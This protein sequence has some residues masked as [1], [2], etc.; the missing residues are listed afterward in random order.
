MSDSSNSSPQYLENLL[1]GFGSLAV[2]ATFLAGTQAQ[3][4]SISIGITP[5]TASIRATNVLW[6]SGLILDLMAAFLS[7]LTSRWLQRLSREEKMLLERVFDEQ[8]RNTAR[9]RDY[10]DVEGG[11]EKTSNN[12]NAGDNDIDHNLHAM[13]PLR[14]NDKLVEICFSTSLLVSMPLL[15]FGSLCMVVGLI[16][17]TWSQHPTVVASIVTGIFVVNL[18]F[19]AGVIL[20]SR[21]SSRRRAI[22]HRLSAMQGTW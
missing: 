2:G 20:I 11:V 19:L 7:Y 1:R 12:H 15:A 5:E 8:Q 21:K 9:R 3:V 22:I 16:V 6:L 17:Y 18:P 10:L 14:W 4:L 13:K